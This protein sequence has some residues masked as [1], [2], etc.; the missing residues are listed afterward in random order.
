MAEPADSGRVTPAI[1]AEREALLKTLVASGFPGGYDELA[2]RA[3]WMTVAG[4]SL[5]VLVAALNDIHMSKRVADRPKD[6]AYFLAYY[7][8][9]VE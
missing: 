8:C 1:D 2:A 9:T 5:A 6:R 7:D 4:T 3:E